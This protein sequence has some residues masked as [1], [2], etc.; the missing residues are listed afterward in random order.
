MGQFV[1]KPQRVNRTQFRHAAAR[2]CARWWQRIWHSP[3]RASPAHARCGARLETSLWKMRFTQLAPTL[4]SSAERPRWSGRTTSGFQCSRPRLS[5]RLRWR[6][7]W[8][9]TSA[10]R[11]GRSGRSPLSWWH[12]QPRC[13]L[14]QPWK[15]RHVVVPW[16][17]RHPRPCLIRHPE[18]PTRRA[19]SI[20]MPFSLDWSWPPA[21]S[22]G[23]LKSWTPEMEAIR[24]RSDHNALLRA[25]VMSWR[26]GPERSVWGVPSHR[27]RLRQTSGP[28]H[29][30][31]IGTA[32]CSG[33]ACPAGH[34]R[35]ERYPAAAT[36]CIPP[37][38]SMPTAFAEPQAV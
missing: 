21:R 19:P 15:M 2:R 1:V 6:A 31:L 36:P 32:M 37:E 8:A 28:H 30:L 27:R 24:S 12:V 10:P 20:T 35:P 4:R 3:S 33:G 9:P 14:C 26:V 29:F 38:A 16:A 18:M 17:S 22:A 5:V 25:S 23:R 7:G 11:R 13:E 34:T